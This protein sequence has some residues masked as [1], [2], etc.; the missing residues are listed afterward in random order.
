ML[1]TKRLNLR[2]WQKSDAE[3]LCKYASN[4]DV[5]LPAGWT[6][7]TSPEYSRE[8][9]QTVLSAPEIYA[10][11]LKETNLP[12]GSIG[13]MQNKNEAEL[14]YW[15]GVPYWGQGLIPEAANELI[16]H[17]FE[18]LNLDTIWCGYY[19][20]NEKSKRVQEKCGFTFHH[21]EHD[22]PCRNLN[23]RR[24]EYVTRLTKTEWRER[25]DAEAVAEN[26]NNIALGMCF[27]MALGLICGTVF[28]NI[29]IG[30]CFGVAFGPLIGTLIKKRT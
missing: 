18:D 29:G 26:G 23:E 15:L 25:K 16:R 1:T 24:T 30:L 21:I 7:H 2:P 13:F 20:G 8:I 5:A 14:G 12:I 4:P 22:K 27:G 28:G 11:I 3:E 17:G 19:E 10:V 9:I 6:P